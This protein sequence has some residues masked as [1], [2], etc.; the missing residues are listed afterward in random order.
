M[1]KSHKYEHTHIVH[2]KDGSHTVHHHHESSDPKDHK[3]Y[4]VADHDGMMDGMMAHTSE[5]DE[6]EASADAG[7][8]GIPDDIAQKA[9][10]SGPRPTGA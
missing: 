10:M 5:P 2:H 6:E 3:D 4:G 9:G 8:H 1:A 7:E